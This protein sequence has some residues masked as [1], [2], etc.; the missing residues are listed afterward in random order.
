MFKSSIVFASLIATTAAVAQNS[1]RQAPKGLSTEGGRFVFGQI[2]DSRLDRFM[3]DTKTGRL[4]TIVVT[5]YIDN[6]GKE[7]TSAEF[8]TPVTY[9]DTQ[10]N[11]SLEPIAESLPK[12]K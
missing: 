8:L 2:S 9:H 12:V 11:R 6:E 4:W 10:G 7:R 1:D 3:L 5:K